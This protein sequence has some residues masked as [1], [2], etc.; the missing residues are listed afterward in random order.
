MTIGTF[1]MNE[2]MA[3]LEARLFESSTEEEKDK[4]V[5][6]ETE[7]KD[8]KDEKETT[9]K[10]SQANIA[11]K[12]S[13][14]KK[15]VN[16]PEDKSIAKNQPPKE[17]GS[18]PKSTAKLTTD[19]NATNPEEGIIIPKE[20]KNFYDWLKKE[21]QKGQT[22]VKVEYK[23]GTSKFEPGYVMQD[24]T[25]SA[26]KPSIMTNAKSDVK[27]PKQNDVAAKPQQ[28]TETKPVEKKPETKAPEK[29]TEAKPEEKEGDKK[30]FKPFTKKEDKPEEKKEEKKLVRE[31][32]TIKK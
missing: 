2:Y 23:V 5:E 14:T 6:E 25:A 27:A 7:E 22:E 21:Y 31:S 9:P 4:K 18:A 26:F 3:R 28:K 11:S 8:E 20:N 30:G 19:G 15:G 24:K 16:S 29:K 1:N 12:P 10:K 32:I 13:D 17:V